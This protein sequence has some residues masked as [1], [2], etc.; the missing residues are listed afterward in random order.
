MSDFSRQ[1]KLTGEQGISR[2]K[3]AHVVIF[4]IGGVGG[5]AAEALARAA[6][7]AITL[8]DS[9]DVDLTNIN[10]QIIA[11]STTVGKPKSELMSARIADINP[12]CVVTAKK[13][14]VTADNITAL[15][16]GISYAVDA[17]DNV[18]AKLAII[19]ACRQKGIPVISSMGAGN[20][21]S[22]VFRVMDISETSNDGLAKVM[23]RELRKRD[24][25]HVKCVC[26]DEQALFSPAAGEPISSISY[27][28]GL[29]GLTLAGEA[30]RD[31]IG[32]NI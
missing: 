2:L 10:R 20:R 30:I 14:F 8:V 24:I 5:Y 17:V 32:G 4:G 1:Q 22:G 31:I 12:D 29:C 6:V 18:T 19:S 21:V 3:E 15:L 23:R 25:E 16:E 9:D 27:M 11:L 13:I 26:C 7:G 28:P